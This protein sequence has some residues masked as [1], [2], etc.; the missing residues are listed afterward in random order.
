MAGTERYAN[1]LPMSASSLEWLM[2]LVVEHRHSV[3][4]ILGFQVA[5]TLLYALGRVQTTPD[6][7]IEDEGVTYQHW[8]GD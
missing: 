4:A 1:T 2:G 7:E 6:A 3:D 8:T 5:E